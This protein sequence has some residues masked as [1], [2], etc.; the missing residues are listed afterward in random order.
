MYPL[1]SILLL[2][3]L[4]PHCPSYFSSYSTFPLSTLFLLSR[5]IQILYYLSISFYPVHCRVSL[6]LPSLR[7]CMYVCLCL[8]V[9]VCLSLSASLSR[10]LSL[11]VYLS[12]SSLLRRIWKQFKDVLQTLPRTGLSE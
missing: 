7:L 2:L 6:C 5:V 9:S 12:L 8:S 4:F 11:S 3:P 1:S 10:S